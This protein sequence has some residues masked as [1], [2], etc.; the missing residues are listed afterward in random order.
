MNQR[1]AILLGVLLL[2]G[3]YLSHE[4]GEDEP[5]RSHTGNRAVFEATGG[6]Q[7][8]VVPPGVTS[9]N[10]RLW[11]A[12]G[13]SCAEERGG[14]GGFAA[15][16]ELAVLPEEHLE[17]VVGV[18]GSCDPGSNPRT[19]GGGGAGSSH[20][21]YPWSGSGGGRSAI[22]RPLD[23]DGDELI[24]AGGGGGIGYAEVSGRGGDGCGG[25][26][27]AGENGQGEGAGRGGGVDR[28]GQGGIGGFP[29]GEGDFLRGADGIQR[30]VDP[31]ALGTSG[32]GGG[33]W[34][35]GGAGA[36]LVHVISG[37]GGGGA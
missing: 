36:W 4:L 10:V 34:F 26:G 7:L 18:A 3:C 29:G 21:R 25:R 23:F 32:G 22:R 20:P 9:V 37:P 5:V 13:G 33:G 17:I 27:G 8:F 12:A 1:R 6:P 16:Q 15:H 11:G 31:S 2:P 14:A 24:T 35:G 28:G 30:S 19:Y